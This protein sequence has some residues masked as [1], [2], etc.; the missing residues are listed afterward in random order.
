MG[1]HSG[2][3]AA[4]PVHRKSHAGLTVGLI[5]VILLVAAILVFRLG[6]T[7]QPGLNTAPSTQPAVQTDATAPV[8]TEP[9]AAPADTPVVTPTG[10]QTDIACKA[11]YTVAPDAGDAE[12]I[13]ATAGDKQ[14]TNGMLQILYL[15]QVNAYRAAEAE[16]APDFSRPLDCQSCP[17]EE[18]LSWQHY[19]LKAAILSWQAQQ[20]LLLQASRPQLITEEGF[21]PNETDDLHGKYVAPEL[22]VNDFL[23][24]DLPCYTPNRLHQ[25][26]LDTMEQTL[27]ALA[28]G[29]GFDGLGA[30]AQQLGVSA[31]DFLQAALDYNT[32]YMYF[33]EKSYDFSPTDEEISDYLS[34]HQA[35]LSGTGETADIRHILLI[36]EGAAVAADGTVSATETQWDQVQQK[37]QE[38]LS[39]W[40]IAIPRQGKDGAFAQ[41]AATYSQ[42]ETTRADGGLLYQ[43]CAADLVEPLN[44]WCFSNA[45]GATTVLRRDDGLHIIFLSARGQTDAAAAKNILVTQGEWDLWNQWL[46]EVPLTP[47]YSA[48]ALWADTTVAAF[49][50]AD[51]LYPDIAHQRFPEAITYFQQDFN[52]VPFGNGYIGSNGCG[53][54]TYAMLATYM[55]DSLQTPPM[56]S[57][58]FTSKYFDYESHGTDGSI[59][60]QAPAEMGFYFDRTT[61][62][63]KEVIAAL[64]NGQVVVSLQQKGHFTSKGHYLLLMHYYPEDDTIQVRDS[65]IFNYGHLEG[66]TVDRFSRS[67]VADASTNY[68]I[69]QPKITSIPACCR[70]GNG[71]AA[72]CPL[73]TRDY[74]CEKCTAALARRNNFLSLMDAR[75]H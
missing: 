58:R 13:V 22:P 32:A 46:E 4:S 20:A 11:S 36:P 74:L 66:H 41:L 12:T 40:N 47:D 14:L 6:K 39:A 17:L 3:Y 15:S 60:R 23:Y 55:T 64:E 19:F 48:V 71:E 72:P 21:H 43:L 1:K 2:K 44:E 42:D 35:E 70:C 29:A 63:M 18:G 54:T 33:T 53:I 28:S 69:M 30:M 16:I 73:L 9:A 65:N 5:L 37:A 27:D 38:I 31:G 51:T 50:L 24:Q 10:N 26:Y 8:S 7:P 67:L 25:E 52:Y 62:D 57:R 45:P 59:F 56:M 49:A 68:Y 75:S 61:S 34:E